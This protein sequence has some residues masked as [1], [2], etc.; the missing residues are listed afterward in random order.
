MKSPAIDEL[1][2]LPETLAVQRHF[3]ARN[4]RFFRWLLGCNLVLLIAAIAASLSRGWFISL[5]FFLA[6]LFATMALVALRQTNFFEIYFR[7]ILLAYL[8]LCIILLKTLSLHAEHGHG[9]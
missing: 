5:G 4:Y 8:F 1:V 3:D 6:G 9:N 7:Q 2:L